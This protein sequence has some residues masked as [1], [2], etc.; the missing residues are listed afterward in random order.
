MRYREILERYHENGSTF[1]HDGEEYDLD[2]LLSLSDKL[3]IDDVPIDQLIWVFG[4]DDPEEDP[5]RV[6]KADVTAPIL[7]TWWIPDRTKSRLVVLD[8]LH[9]VA[10]AEQLGMKTIPARYIDHDMLQETVLS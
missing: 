3:P 2:K 5:K 6:A 1:T 8:G 9:R 4:H 7:V 10:R